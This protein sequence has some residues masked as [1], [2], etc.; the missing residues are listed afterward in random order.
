MKFNPDS[1]IK[2]AYRLAKLAQKVKDT[3]DPNIFLLLKRESAFL[4][5]RSF[6]FW[7]SLRFE[8][9]PWK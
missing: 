1:V 7:L 9:W 6:E 2:S 3:Q 8:W 4:L 5:R